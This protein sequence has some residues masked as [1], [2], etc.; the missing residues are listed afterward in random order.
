[1]SD[2]KNCR[3]GSGLRGRSGDEL[4]GGKSV[5]CTE[6]LS[7]NMAN[8]HEH[9]EKAGRGYDVDEI[10]QIKARHVR[11]ASEPTAVSPTT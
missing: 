4:R 8:E 6:T 7:W 5:L 1:M 11:V 10:T 9:Q 3:R 2:E